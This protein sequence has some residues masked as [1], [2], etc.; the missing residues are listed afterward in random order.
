V[1][2]VQKLVW[3]VTLV[4]ELRPGVMTLSTDDVWDI[5]A[6][7]RDETKKRAAAGELTAQ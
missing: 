5:I 1:G 2:L 3:R 4:A 6:F 7:L